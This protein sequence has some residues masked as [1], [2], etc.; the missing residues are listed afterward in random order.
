L[1]VDCSFYRRISSIPAIPD[2]MGIVVNC[3]T[4]RLLPDLEQ[5][6]GYFCFPAVPQDR[7]FAFVKWRLPGVLSLEIKYVCYKRVPTRITGEEL[8]I[9]HNFMELSHILNKLFHISEDYL[10]T[11]FLKNVHLQ[12]DQI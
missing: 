4:G 7:S 2:V 5:M 8:L 9:P 6:I 3:G 11:L 12:L 10:Y 1:K